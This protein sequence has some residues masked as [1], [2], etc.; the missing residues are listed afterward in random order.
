MT[1][2]KVRR[3]ARIGLPLL[4]FLP[5]CVLGLSSLGLFPDSLVLRLSI[6]AWLPVMSLASIAGSIPGA[7]LTAIFGGLAWS[8]LLAKGLH[9]LALVIT[10]EDF[11]W[12]AFKAGMVS[13]SIVGMI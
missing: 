10:A 9:E 12:Y 11:E 6:L 4:A 13:G 1:P 3:Y 8:S 5:G 2:D 7:V